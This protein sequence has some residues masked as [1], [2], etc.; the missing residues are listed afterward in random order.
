MPINGLN[1][2]EFAKDLA[3]Q[4]INYV[5][6]DLTEDQK[7]YVSRKVF[8]FSLIA[9]NHL[10]ERYKQQFND[11]Q[12]RIIVQ[13]IGEWTFHKSIDLIRAQI[14]NKHWDE[15]LQQIAF[16]ALQ[17]AIQSFSQNLEQVQ[18]ATNIEMNVMEAYQSCLKKLAETKVIPENQVKEALTYS[19]VDKMAQETSG[20][21]VTD[22]EKILKYTAIAIVLKKM[23]Q[24]KIEQIISNFEEE[25][26]KHIISFLKI[27]NIEQKVNP[28]VISKYLEELKKNVSNISKPNIT[29]T[30]KSINALKTEFNTEEIFNVIS[31]ERSQIHDLMEKSL[32]ETTQKAS[33]V[34][35]SPY[36]AK[37]IY[38][39]VK[40]N[41]VKQET[42]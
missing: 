24:E 38:D 14:P 31:Y 10:L 8:D 18:I 5:P 6:A 37:V 41:L 3:Q 32:F 36:I 26:Q 9:G 15:I 25:E 21:I 2:Q 4:A 7:N 39:H 1:P 12:A 11:D 20:P 19:N 35:I 17:T 13:F 42:K 29:K 16:V 22:E 28:A 33:K 34:K 23:P 40:S 27:E 30:V